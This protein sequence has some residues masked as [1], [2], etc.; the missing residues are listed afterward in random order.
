VT[1]SGHPVIVWFLGSVGENKTVQTLCNYHTLEEIAGFYCTSGVMERFNNTVTKLTD[2]N[3]SVQQYST[4]TINDIWKKE[5]Q[6]K[7][8]PTHVVRE[9]NQN[10]ARQGQRI[11]PLA[12]VSRPALGPTQPPV[13]CVPGSKA[14]PWRDADHSPLSSAEVVNE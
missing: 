8:K 3:W 9:Q 14:R 1:C 13:Q 7:H 4:L 2:C 10:V 11:F 6:K 12:S 5:W